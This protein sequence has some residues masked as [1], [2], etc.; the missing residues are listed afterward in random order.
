MQLSATGES[1]VRGY[2]FIL[3]RSLR[4]FL[5][6]AEALDA[7]REVESHIMDRVAETDAVPDERTAIGRVLAELGAPLEVARA[8]SLEM[9]AE[10]AVTTGRIVAIAR[11]LLQIAALGIRGFFAAIAVFVGY[12][13]GL[14]FLAIAALKPIFPDNVGLFLVDGVPRNFGAQFPRPDGVLVGG[15][16]VIVVSATIGV[17]MLV[18]THRLARRLIASW[19]TRR[20]ARS[21]MTIPGR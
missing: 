15:Y 5:P 11:S 18:F 14:A 1:R 16:W 13:M 19:L 20:R 17:A 7:S 12:V 10:E 2:L 9:A 3:E 4:T 6:R 21:A 8:Y